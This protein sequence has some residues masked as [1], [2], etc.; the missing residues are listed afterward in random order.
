MF[1]EDYWREK[2]E[3]QERAKGDFSVRAMA[4]LRGVFF[5]EDEPI[6]QAHMRSLTN[7]GRDVPG[8][9]HTR[10]LKQ[11]RMRRIRHHSMMRNHV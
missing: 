5:V 3:R 9:C 2:R 7:S 10:S 8:K 1:K 6:V 4:F 11:R